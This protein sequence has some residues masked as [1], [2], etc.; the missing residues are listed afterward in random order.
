ML[1]QKLNKLAANF[2]VSAYQSLRETKIHHTKKS[3]K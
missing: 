3:Y 2:K 1:K